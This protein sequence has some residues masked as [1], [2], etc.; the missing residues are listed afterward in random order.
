MAAG[1]LAVWGAILLWFWSRGALAPALDAIL[2]HN[3]AYASDL[4][5]AERWGA[6]QFFVPPLLPSQGAAWVL[7]AIGLVALALRRDRFPA[8][9]LG[10]FAAVNALAVS[11]SGF[12]FPHYFQQVLP[13]VA[14]LAAAAI[15][16][17][18]A[19]PPRWRVAGGSA[20]AIAPLLVVAIGFWRISPAEATRRIYPGNAFEAIPALAAELAS[21]TAPDDRVFVFGAEPELLFHARR[22]SAT[23]YIFLFPVFNAFRDAEA[24]QA[25]VITEVLGARPAA[26]VWMPLQSFFGRGRPQRLTEWTTAHIDAHYRLAAYATTDAGGRSEVRRVAPGEDVRAQLAEN[27]P[28]AK[29]FVRAQ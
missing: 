5:R 21:Q 25:E 2:F 18:H 4:T 3:L 28:W 11:A 7:A 24:R 12:Y 13:A 22:V 16:G 20:L 17:A 23:R 9:F 15:A 27:A 29:I 14:A 6:L 19:V 10:G 26:I 8:L 1:G